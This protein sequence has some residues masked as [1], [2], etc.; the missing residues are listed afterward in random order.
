MALIID[1]GLSARE[2]Q[3]RAKAA[4]LDMVKA[5][6]IVVSHEHR[7]HIS[8]VGPL[9]RSLK[10][11]VFFNDGAWAEAQSLTG[12]LKRERFVTGDTIE[13]GPLKLRSLPISHDAADPVA[14]VFESQAGRLGLATDLGAPTT[15]IRHNFQELSG[16]ILEF[17][18]DFSLLMDGP[19]PW[20]L[21]QR[22]RSRLGHLAN[23]VAAELAAE[24]WHRELK[25]LVLAHLSETNNSPQLAVAAARQVLPEGALE[26]TPAAQDKATP[27]FEF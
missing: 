27:V 3:A 17:N 24:L 7:D 19:Y 15:L 25:H 9:A 2:F 13:F 20:P 23:D 11:P 5:A 16:L 4:G 21:K 18:H 10:I 14:F 12:R 26:P 8:G 6:A 22:V 1:C